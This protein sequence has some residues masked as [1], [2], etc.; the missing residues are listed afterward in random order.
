MEVYQ[1]P[2]L[3]SPATANPHSPRLSFWN[4][5]SGSKDRIS[6]SSLFGLTFRPFPGEFAFLQK[7]KNIWWGIFSWIRRWIFSPRSSVVPEDTCTLCMRGKLL[8]LCLTLWDPLDC[9]Q[10]GSSLS[11]GFSRQEYWSGFPCSPP[12]DLPDPGIKP[13]SPA[14][15]QA[16]SLPLSHQG[17]PYRLVLWLKQL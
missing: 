10:P 4:W 3:F 11:M 7:K 12:G 17:R 14:I 15:L 6:A 5:P 2:Q 8:Q 1:N 9:T 13:V 16:E